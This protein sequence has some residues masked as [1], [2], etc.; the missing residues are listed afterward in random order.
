M[1]GDLVKRLLDL[2]QDCRNEGKFAQ[3]YLETRG[4]AI[5]TSFSLRCDESEM[6]IR[7]RNHHTLRR[8]TPSQRRRDEARKKAWLEKK[9]IRQSIPTPAHSE[10]L[11]EKVEEPEDPGSKTGPV[12]KVDA[13]PQLDGPHEASVNIEEEAVEE[14]ALDREAVEEEALD[15]EAVE[16]EAVE[17][18]AV[19]RK[20]VEREAVERKD[21]DKEHSKNR[22]Q[23]RIF[24]FLSH[25]YL[26]QS[27]RK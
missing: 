2:F 17:R 24:P 7:D 4:G 5:T 26:K 18:E 23:S 15:R 25:E 14:E 1:S 22:E 9:G 20:S 11:S 21:V 13:I 19:E 6:N 3:L 12:W 16:R 27:G 8:K 10:S